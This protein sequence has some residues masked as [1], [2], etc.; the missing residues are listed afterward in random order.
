MIK[1]VIALGIAALCMCGC[2][3]RRVRTEV[4]AREYETD[5]S[6]VRAETIRFSGFENSEFE[7]E[8]N[9]Q[10]Q[11]SLESE[12]VA[13]DSEASESGDNV[14]MGNK[15]V[16]EITWEGKYN[17]S[18]FIS[19]VEEKYVYTGGAHGNTV[20]IPKNIDLAA[21]REIKLADL[22]EDDG[23]TAALNRLINE[24]LTERSGEYG[25]LWAKPEIK[26]S[27]QTDFYISG[28]KLVIFFQPYDLSYY[29]R[30]FVEFPIDLEDLSGYMKEE[31]RRLAE[32]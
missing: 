3:I 2:D 7:N 9:E 29:A 25:D 4:S 16:L 1:R 23:Y 28:D 18:D 24:R 11:Q 20:R 10:I 30:G 15:C 12:L 19:V 21:G 17:E 27:H 22:F 8:L 31:Y 32:K 14:R 26:Q 5:F 13:F 6:A